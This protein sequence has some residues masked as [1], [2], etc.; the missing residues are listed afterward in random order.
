MNWPAALR[1]FTD[2]DF[3]ILDRHGQICVRKKLR[4]K[5]FSE[6]LAESEDFVAIYHRHLSENSDK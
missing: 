6:F 2:G 1:K 5:F 3:L 4:E